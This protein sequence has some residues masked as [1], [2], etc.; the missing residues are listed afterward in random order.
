MKKLIKVETNAS[1]IFVTYDTEEKIVRVLDNEETN[2]DVK[3][4]D[5]EDDT[6]WDIFEDV[7]NIEEWLGIDYNNP[8][9]P[10]I[11]EELEFE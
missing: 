1:T 5:V 11:V 9:T 10:R 4:N 6:S 2:S 8:D 7:E 3:L